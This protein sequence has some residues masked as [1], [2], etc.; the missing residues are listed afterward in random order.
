LWLEDDC[1]C[2]LEYATLMCGQMDADENA[3]SE[4]G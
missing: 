3:F 2:H 1:A 4:G